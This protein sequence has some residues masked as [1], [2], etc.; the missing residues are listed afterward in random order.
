MRVEYITDPLPLTIFSALVGSAGIAV[1]LVMIVGCY[2]IG[3][4][5][6]SKLLIKRGW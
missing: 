5:V 1:G 3:W 2:W 4:Q 6:Y